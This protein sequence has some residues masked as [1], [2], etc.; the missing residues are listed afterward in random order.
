SVPVPDDEFDTKL[1]HA[2]KMFNLRLVQARLAIAKGDRESAHKYALQA[3]DDWK[4]M[5]K[6]YEYT[7]Q[8][9][10][11]DLFARLGIEAP[12]E[13]AAG[14]SSQTPGLTTETDKP[15]RDWAIVPRFVQTLVDAINMDNAANSDAVGA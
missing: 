7:E 10:N 5:L 14:Q 4:R 6:N 13:A 8:E 1:A 9:L 15:W 3:I 12:A 11:A 2:N